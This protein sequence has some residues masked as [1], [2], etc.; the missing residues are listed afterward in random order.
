MVDS[1]YY[2]KS[3]YLSIQQNN[4]QLHYKIHTLFDII[5]HASHTNI[6]AIPTT[7]NRKMNPITASS[8]GTANIDNGTHG[9]HKLLLKTQVSE[10]FPSKF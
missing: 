4:D 8:T 6:S 9:T 3:L 10:G 2:A 5:T 7:M 1:L